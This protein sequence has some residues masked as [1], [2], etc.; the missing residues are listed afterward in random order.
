[1]PVRPEDLRP[2]ERLSAELFQKWLDRIGIKVTW[3]P[4]EHDPPDL[5]FTIERDTPHRSVGA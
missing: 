4:V 2:E 3:E 1:M 5:S